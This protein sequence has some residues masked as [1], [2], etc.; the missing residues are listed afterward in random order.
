MCMIQWFLSLTRV[1]YVHSEIRRCQ[2]RPWTENKT[3]KV[4]ACERIYTLENEVG[5]R[6]S[7]FFLGNREVIL[8]SPF[9]FANPC[10][11]TT[12]SE[13]KFSRRSNLRY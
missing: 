12:V 7:K 8:E 9:A 3:N 2:L 1:F 4:Y 10:S 6:G 11:D 5:V 13:W